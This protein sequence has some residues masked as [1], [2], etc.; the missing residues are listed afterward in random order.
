VPG[1]A[2]WSSL[3]ASADADVIKEHILTGFK[4]GKPFAPYRPTMALS[5]PLER[6]LDFGCGIGRNFPFLASIA[7]RVVGFDLPPMIARCRALA[8]VSVDRLEDNWAVLRRERFDLIFASL[9][10][11]HLETDACRSFLADFVQIAPRV[12]LLTR[13]DSDFGVD[14]LDLVADEPGLRAGTCVEVEHDSDTN[15]LRVLGRRSLDEARTL[16]G[17]RHY[18]II[19]QTA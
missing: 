17:S 19:L 10:F 9:V 18:E 6:V 3:A 14:V 16:G 7:G 12:Y 11:Q 1:S 13:T 15:Q 2:D 4:D 8:T 5:G